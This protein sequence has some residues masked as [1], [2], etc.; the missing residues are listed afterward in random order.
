[1]WRR[2]L[3]P[4]SASSK[5]PVLLI[6]E[7]NDDE[8]ELVATAL[9]SEPAHMEVRRVPDGQACMAYLDGQDAYS[10][11]P[12]PDLLLLDINMPRMNGFDVMAKD[13]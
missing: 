3:S 1:M 8:F 9:M 7:D 11:M 10:G 13:C 4:H 12:F 6:A 5:P 2:Q